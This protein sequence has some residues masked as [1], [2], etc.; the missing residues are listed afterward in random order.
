MD[1]KLLETYCRDLVIETNNGNV[2][3]EQAVDFLYSIISTDYVLQNLEQFGNLI[4]YILNSKIC[5]S[6]DFIYHNNMGKFSEGDFVLKKHIKKWIQ[7]SKSEKNQILMVIEKMKFAF[8]SDQFDILDEIL[9]RFSMS[10]TNGDNEVIKLSDFESNNNIYEDL[11]EV[12]F[13]N[14]ETDY[15]NVRELKLIFLS[16][17]VYKKADFEEMDRYFPY[18]WLY[19]ND[20]GLEDKQDS[21]V[22][23]FRFIDTKVSRKAIPK[24]IRYVK[25][26][27]RRL[28]YVDDQYKDISEM[29]H[30]GY[31]ATLPPEERWNILINRVIPKLGK[32]YTIKFLQ[33]LINS[34]KCQHDGKF[35][36][37]NAISAWEFD[38]RQ[39]KQY[40]IS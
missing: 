19:K 31:S 7:L 25:K 3:E 17:W 27:S 33:S 18:E 30:L 22:D 4:N 28:G 34:R 26:E 23:D 20:F 16:F 36:Y 14:E 13:S 11:S 40:V 21:S 35:K 37:S 39:L 2:P 32:Q 29:G 6:F 8:L 1:I 38:I 5:L 9:N 12:L 24:L 10:S 15:V